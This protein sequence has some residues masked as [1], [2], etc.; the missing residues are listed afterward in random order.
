MRLV[1]DDRVV[2][3]EIIA[4]FGDLEQRAFRMLS[5]SKL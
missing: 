4:L 5:M 2:V 3:L 1:D